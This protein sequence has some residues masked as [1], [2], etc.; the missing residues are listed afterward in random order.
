MENKNYALLSVTNKDGIINFA[1]KL[2][3][4][5]N[6]EVISTG[7]TA[8]IIEEA[9]IRVLRC[10]NYTGMK[11]S[12]LLK[13]MHHKIS[14]GLFYSD[15]GEEALKFREKLNLNPISVVANNF[16][17]TK[18]GGSIEEFLDNVDVGG[19]TMTR[20]AAKMA[21]KH[22]SVT[23]LTDPS[24]YK[25]ALT[26]LKTHGEVQRNLINEL[27]VTAFR[28]LKEYNVQIDD[29]LTNYSTEHPGWAR[30]I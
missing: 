21:L 1:N 12:K 14:G 7:G 5:H 27:G 24:Q 30:K 6:F 25:L 17:L 2:V 19:P 28:R 4:E 29:F 22:G 10:E 23:I 3:Q 20:T 13:T 11:E 18:T 8:D 9:G 15:N 26:D 16:Y